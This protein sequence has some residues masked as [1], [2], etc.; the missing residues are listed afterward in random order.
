[1]AGVEQPEAPPQR[2]ALIMSMEEN[3]SITSQLTTFIA[4]TKSSNP[5]YQDETSTYW[6]AYKAKLRKQALEPIAAIHVHDDGASIQE[7]GFGVQ[8]VQLNADYA[9]AQRA[10]GAL[11]GER[12]LPGK[13]ATWGLLDLM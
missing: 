9:P 6:N 3:Q 1:M 13:T 7:V 8:P 5:G 4:K 11:E 12:R 10:F 2:E